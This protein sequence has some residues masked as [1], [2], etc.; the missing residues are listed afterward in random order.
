M[1]RFH[2]RLLPPVLLIGILVALTA[3]VA[4]QSSA[5]SQIKSE[6]SRLQQSIKDN[7]IS[8]PNFKNLITTIVDTLNAAAASVDAGHLFLSLEKLGQAEDLL[9]GGRAVANS[10]E[11]EKNSLTAFEAHWGKVSLRLTAL[12]KDAHAHDWKHSA[13]AIRALAEA[14]QGK[15]IPLLEGGRG[16]AT[17]NG[18]KDGLF[19][20]GQAEGEAD[21]ATFCARLNAPAKTTAS[22]LRSLLPE[23]HRLQEKTNA[24]FQPPK[25]IDLHPRFIA[26]NSQIKL[27]EELDA[28]RFYAG[29]LYAYLDAVRHYGML[30]APPLDTAAQPQ[31][32][33]DLSA[34]SKKLAA[35]S[36]DNSTDDS[37]AQLFLERAVS[38][39]THPDGSAPTADE[40]RGARVILDQVLPAYYDAQKPAAPLERA[41]GK[42]VDITLV[43]WPYT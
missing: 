26:L 38:Y 7:P 15:A 28:S 5:A 21:F 42:V 14:A 22:P 3:P 35:S 12:D 29:A 19:Y 13:L 17:A 41:S 24:A 34:A 39:T 11:V 40:W 31:L 23:L 9:Q 25:S 43:R 20:V 27:A 16:F 10:A 1:M 6:I 37:I 32:K 4:A 33:Q 36:A 18:P 30:D 2:P 8:D